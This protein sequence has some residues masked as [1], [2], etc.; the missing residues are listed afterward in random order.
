MPGVA[1]GKLLVGLQVLE[2][3]HIISEIILI[4]G[5]SKDNTKEVALQN[6][7]PVQVIQQ[8]QPGY[9]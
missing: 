9:G 6:G 8:T 4:D 7:I 5:G 2:S 3:L 1:Y